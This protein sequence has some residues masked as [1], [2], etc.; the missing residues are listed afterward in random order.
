MVLARC[1]SETSDPVFVEQL[2]GFVAAHPFFK[3]LQM[4]GIFL[5]AG[6]RHL[7]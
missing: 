2:L 5:D 1:S 7:M 3:Q 6:E 4:R